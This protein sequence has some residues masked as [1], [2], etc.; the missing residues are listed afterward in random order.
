[1]MGR[2]TT[3]SLRK[4]LALGD[5]FKISAAYLGVR[6]F[7]TTS[8]WESQG[9]DAEEGMD[10]F[11]NKR[12]G[13]TLLAEDISEDFPLTLLIGGLTMAEFRVM[14]GRLAPGVKLLEVDSSWEGGPTTVVV[15]MAEGQVRSVFGRGT[16]TRELAVHRQASPSR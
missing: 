14:A 4:E 8:G 16:K 15:A 11:R 5:V 2:N 1:M 12:T 7:L 3:R 13:E 10:S 9:E 6:R